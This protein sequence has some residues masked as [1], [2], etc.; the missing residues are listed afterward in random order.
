MLVN[1]LTPDLNPSEQGCLPEFLYWAF[2][3]YCLLLKKN[4]IVSHTLFLEAK[5]RAHS[6]PDVTWACA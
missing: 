5:E 3:F 1:H 2:K 4:K 6:A